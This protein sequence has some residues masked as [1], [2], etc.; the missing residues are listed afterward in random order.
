MIIKVGNYMDEFMIKEVP[1]ST[2]LIT[3]EVVSGDEIVR[4]FYRDEDNHIKGDVFDWGG[5]ITSF[6]DFGY[7]LDPTDKEEMLSWS[8]RTSTYDPFPVI[9]TEEVD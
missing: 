1:D 3:V 2:F 8:N 6:E 9:E 5:R 4:I 7:Y